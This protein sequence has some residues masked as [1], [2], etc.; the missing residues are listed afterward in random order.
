VNV[1]NAHSEKINS[2]QTRQAARSGSL[3][4][5]LAQNM[6]RNFAQWFCTLVRPPR[7]SYARFSASAIASVIG[8]FVVIVASMFLF[9]ATASEWARHEPNWFRGVF[10][11]I[12]DFGL[13]GW[14][15][16]PL[17][18]LLLVLAMIISPQLPRL[19]QGVLVALAGRFGF[20]FL[21]IG[22]SG[23]FVT[24]VKRLIGRARPYVGGHDDPFAYV[25]F[26]W[27]PE[28]ASMPSGHA[29]TAVAAALAIGAIWP[30]T[31]IVM[32]LYAALIM[33]SRVAVL[34]HHVSDVIAGALVAAGGTYL[35]RRWFA[36]RHLVFHPKDLRASCGPSLPRIK[37]A[38]RQAIS[39]CGL[40]G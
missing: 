7:A 9:D 13:S 22:L 32:W 3:A 16:F 18:F 19:T 31:R 24:I 33:I 11:H 21:A 8:T 36:A 40:R 2:T 12:T 6:A 10:E 35:I 14:F 39:G 25:P 15:L 5:R 20:L 29:T 34:A 4:G 26:I 37:K 27:R 23:L 38:L 28:Y 1:P 30:R 17:G